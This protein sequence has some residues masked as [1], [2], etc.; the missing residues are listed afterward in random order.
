[1]VDLGIDS[2]SLMLKLNTLEESMSDLDKEL[3]FCL[4][5]PLGTGDISDIKLL[6]KE[7]EVSCNTIHLYICIYMNHRIYI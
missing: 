4:K 6:A 5:Q 3:V 2:G 1:M 7:H